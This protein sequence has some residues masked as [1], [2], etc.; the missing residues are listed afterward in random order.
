MSNT[1]KPKKRFE[2]PSPGDQPKEWQEVES[3]VIEFQKQFQDG[4][5]E[6]Q[7]TAS[8]DAGEKLIN[9]FYPFLRKYVVLVTSG[10]I[11]WEDKDQC[12]FVSTFVDSSALKKALHGGKSNSFIKTSILQKFNFVRETYGSKSEDEILMDMQL[13]MITLAKK[14]KVMGRSFCAYVYNAFR[15]SACRMIKEFVTD[16]MNIPYRHIGY[17][18]YMRGS[19]GGEEDRFYDPGREDETPYETEDGL[20]DA[21]WISGKGC[22]DIFSDI[23]PLDRKIL[24]EYYIEK[25]NDGQIAEM[26]GLHIN[27]VNQKRRQAVISIADK[28]GVPKNEIIRSRNSGRNIKNK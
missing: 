27:T 20:P 22:S 28:K 21:F 17:E 4:A 16:P 2:K 6:E 10:Q 11:R 18:D 9:K 1:E 12:L 26:F 19:G 7:I 23:D 25:R 5:S 14:Y 24:I 15:Y 3:L 8:K 13:I